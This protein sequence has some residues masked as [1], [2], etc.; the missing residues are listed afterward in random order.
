MWLTRP[1]VVRD[2]YGW[3]T[4]REQSW[5]WF[6]QVVAAVDQVHDLPVL[7]EFWEQGRP[8]ANS[9]FQHP[10]QSALPDELRGVD[11]WYALN[12]SVDPWPGR[13]QDPNAPLKLDFG[14][15]KDRVVPVW[16]QAQVLGEAPN[17]RWL[18][19]AYAPRA[20]R[21]GVVIH[22]PEYGPVTL[23]VPQAGVYAMV[24][25]G[26]RDTQAVR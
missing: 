3:T 4:P 1:R 20:E 2:F 15:F 18:V 7:S 12:T 10:W 5:P 9:T 6:S 14:E 8:V 23:D 17:R 22:V 11:R 24:T 21:K 13:E 19:F 26:R 25:E 16:A